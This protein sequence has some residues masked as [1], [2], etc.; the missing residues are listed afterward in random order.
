M[1]LD[2]IIIRKCRIEDIPQIIQIYNH[3]ITNTTATFEQESVSQKEMESRFNHISS[4][5]P[6]IVAVQNNTILGYAYAHLWKD[7]SAYSATLEST[8]YLSPLLHNRGIGTKLMTELILQCK[9][10]DIHSLIACIT[11]ENTGSRIFHE[12]LGFRPVSSF[13]EV[14]LK[15]GR[16]LDI[17][18]YQLIIN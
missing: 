14:G 16:L 17:V 3:Y 4:H 8:I 10:A 11:A 1:D 7:K 2:K 13:K 6:Y 5:Y 15:F 12:K 9:K 18:D